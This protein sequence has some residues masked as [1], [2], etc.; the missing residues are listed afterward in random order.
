MYSR[1]MDLTCNQERN[2]VR[3]QPRFFHAEE[4]GVEILAATRY[5]RIKDLAS[6]GFMY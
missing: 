1:E 6:P 3:Y 4:T 2:I 5:V